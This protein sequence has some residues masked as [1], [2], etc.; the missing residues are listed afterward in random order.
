[1]INID[2]TNIEEVRSLLVNITEARQ[3]IGCLAS[4]IH[5]RLESGK[6]QGIKINGQCIVMLRSEVVAIRL[7][8][9]RKAR[10]RSAKEKRRLERLV[11]DNPFTRASQ[12]GSSPV[13]Q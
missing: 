8:K 4:S 1:M 12:S 3:I 13:S 7:E 10:L 9:D 5:R 6:L 11:H 2:E